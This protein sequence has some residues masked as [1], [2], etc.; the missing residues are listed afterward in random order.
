MRYRHELAQPRTRISVQG[1][2]VEECISVRYDKYDVVTESDFTMSFNGKSKKA[3]AKK[4]AVP[5]GK[6]L[7]DYDE[8]KTGSKKA[9]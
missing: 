9:W 6:R 2:S 5:D 1:K 3:N 7:I 8:Y 4:K